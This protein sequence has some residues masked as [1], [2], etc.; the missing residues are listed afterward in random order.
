[1]PSPFPVIGPAILPGNDFH[2]M[3][4]HGTPSPARRIDHT[5][6]VRPGQQRQIRLVVRV[7]HN[8]LGFPVHAE[9]ALDPPNFF[10]TIAIGA[11]EATGQASE[12][13]TLA[14]RADAL[15]KPE[16]RG[17]V[18]KVNVDRKST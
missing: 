17:D 12:A 2:R 4:G 6:L 14:N 10:R 3:T 13:V 7:D 8:T 15:C 18:V 1:M 16:A 11:G 9:M 5:R